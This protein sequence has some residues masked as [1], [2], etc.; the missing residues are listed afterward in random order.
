MTNIKTLITSLVGVSALAMPAQAA[1][2]LPFTTSGQAMMKASNGYSYK[3]L[4][5]VGDVLS[6][7]YQSVGI[8]DGLGAYSLNASTVRVLVNHELGN[9]A[10]KAYSVV[11]GTGGSVSLTGARVSFFDIDRATMGIVNA[12]QSYDR[13]YDRAGNIVANASQI[14]GGFSRFCSSA[15]FEANAFGMGK[16]LVD[17]VYFTGEETAN[18]TMYALDTASNQLYAAPA[19]GRGAWENASQIDT[20]VAGKVAFILNDDTSGNANSYGSPVYMYVGDK[21]AV[22]DGSFLDRNGLAK[23]KMYV[24]VAN[25]G[26][27]NPTTFNGNGSQRDGTWVEI[28][29][30]DASKAGTAGYDAL[31]YAD[32]NTL[33]ANAAAVG[34]FRFSRPEDVATNPGDS[35]LVAFASTGSGLLNGADTWGTIYTLKTSFDANG[36]PVAGAV[37]VVYDGNKD[38]AH[39]LRSPDNLTW[40]GDG[41]LLIQED[42]ATNWAAGGNL[43]EAQ[44]VK[45]TLNGVVTTVAITDRSATQGGIDTLA[46]QLGAWESSGILDVSSLWG[47][48][49]GSLFLGD[50]QAHGLLNGTPLVEGGQLF[51]LTAAGAVPEP[52]TWLTMLVGF[53]AVGVAARKRQAPRIDA[54]C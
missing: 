29:N 32:Q 18:G 27:A 12:G 21:N 30:F 33:R 13:I 19:M 45:V 38:A 36:N 14:A 24:W 20:G 17:R 50:V 34:A 22:G 42:S 54:V 28:K 11:D 9:T 47:L 46:G 10:G 7:G 37:K 39:K 26:D 40:S 41:E 1:N 4:Y 52:A 53:G 5:T 35:T 2:F 16:G 48:K 51:F 8:F 3:A 43:T 44:V 15:A 23:G 25:N 6:N 49:N 31:G